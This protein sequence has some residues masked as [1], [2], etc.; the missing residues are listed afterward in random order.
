MTGGLDVDVVVVGGGPAGLSA[1]L[2]LVR[3]RQRVLVLDG[4]RPRNAATLHSHG[5]LTRDGISP[6]ELR[7]LGREEVA[8][9]D[10]AE[11]QFA[12][13]DGVTAIDGG[14]RVTATG[15]RGAPD[16]D[17]TATRVL[18]A[19]G[20]R[21][22]LPAIGNLRAFYGTA[23]HSCYECDGYEKAGEALAVV[24]ESDDLAERAMHA[25]VWS[26]DIIVFTNGV[27]EVSESDE[28]ML[29][30]SGI[31]VERRVVS[32]FVGERAQLTGLKLA[33]GEVIARTGGFVR[34]L[35]SGALGF[36][37]GLGAETDN[38]GL[39]VVDAHG[40]TSVPGL[41][42]AGDITPPGPEQLIVAAGT[43][44][45]VSATIVR[46]MVSARVPSI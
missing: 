22:T 40:R 35:W 33:D 14:F 28:R 10:D 12:L 45:Q 29:A 26:E 4:N 5:F 6:L 1:A 39:L 18:I 36:L 17:V 31:R 25:S 24:G 20:L 42:A 15:V 9:Y 19:A 3:A 27:G 11:V 37:D 44:A 16:Q 23:L 13:V 43:G 38:L 2:N 8:Q 21:E 30:S 41:Y 34:P 7:K 32:E 46:D